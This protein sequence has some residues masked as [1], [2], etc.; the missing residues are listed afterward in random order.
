M[1]PVGA[2]RRRADGERVRGCLEDERRSVLGVGND[3]NGNYL[4]N[5]VGWLPERARR[6]KTRVSF[7]Q[8]LNADGVIGVPKQ[9]IQTDGTTNLTLVAGQTYN[10]LDTSTG[11]GPTLK[12]AGAD[13]VA[14]NWGPWTPIGAV[15]TATGYD[16]AWKTSDGQFSVWATDANGNYLSNLVVV[17]PGT[18]AAVENLES[19]FGQDLNADGVIGVTK[20]VIQTDGTTNLT[21]VAGQTYNLLDTSTGAGPTLKYAGADVVAGNWGP[22]TPIG[23]VK[24]AT[25]YDVAWKTSDGQFSVWATDANGNYLS[26]LV[27]VVPATS[28]AVLSPEPVFGQ[29]LNGDGV[30]GVTKQVIQTDGTT[31]LT[32]VAGQT[33]NLLDTGTGSGP[34]LK[35]AG[36]DV[37]A[38]NWGPWTPIGAVETAAGYD[39]AWKT[40]DGQFSV[41]ATDSNGNYVSNLVVVAPGTSQALESLEPIFGQDLNNEGVLGIPSASSA[42]AASVLSVATVG[43]DASVFGIAQTLVSSVGTD[44]VSTP[45]SAPNETAQAGPLALLSQYIAA[46]VAAASSGQGGSLVAEGPSGLPSLLAQP[47]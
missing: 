20:Q 6:W 14:G 42:S 44:V 43:F 9:V 21:L 26:N 46:T 36:A 2:D 15:K 19:V 40:S 31:S 11:A 3:A 47:H 10:L 18:S 16:V 4:S 23:A 37:V 27:V 35:Y 33:S 7:G 34:T 5:L 38:G 13:V 24:T 41:W 17:A 30:I 12:Y 1:E 32:L 25:G 22:W 8:D 28:A 39:V 45:P 29:D